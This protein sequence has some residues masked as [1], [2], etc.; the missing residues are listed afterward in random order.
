MSKKKTLLSAILAIAFCMSLIAGSTFALFTSESRVNIAVNSGKVEVVASVSG[1][2]TFSVVNDDEVEETDANYAGEI[3]EDKLGAGKYKYVAQPA[4]QFSEGGTAVYENG[5]L[6]LDKMI[7]GD[8]VT[9]NVDIENNSN[10]KIQ[11][12]TRIDVV[13]DATLFSGLKINIY[14]EDAPDTAV[15]QEK[16]ATISSWK[17]WDPSEDNVKIVKIEIVLPITA[18]NEYQ[19]KGI[20]L[21]FAVEAVQGNAAWA[22]LDRI[23][24]KLA[25][26]MYANANMFDALQD[27]EGIATEDVIKE[28]EFLWNSETDQFT[29]LSAATTDKIKYFKIYDEMPAA[30]SYSIYASSG[31]NTA[32]VN[33]LKVGFDA[34]NASGI[35][36]VTYDRSDAE[37]AQTVIIRTTGG[38]L[39]VNAPLDTVIH[40]GSAA[41]VNIIAAAN[42]SYHEFGAVTFVEIAKGRVALENGSNVSQVHIAKVENTD[43]FDEIILAVASDVK[44]S[45]AG[46]VS[47]AAANETVIT[48]DDVAIAEGGTLVVAL[49]SGTEDITDN[50]ELDYVW[51][52]KQGIYEQIKISDSNESAATSNTVWADDDKVEVKTQSTAMAI[53]NNISRDSETNNIDVKVTISNEA[54]TKT[55]KV[56][57]D[58]NR[59][60][61]VVDKDDEEQTVIAKISDPGSVTVNNTEYTI[62]FASDA[63]NSTE[64][65]ATNSDDETDVVRAPAVENAGLSKDEKTKIRDSAIIKDIEEAD[66]YTVRVGTKGYTD[67]QDALDNLQSNQNIY[68]LADSETAVTIAGV[69][70]V[71]LYLNGY[72]ISVSSG[73][74]LSLYDC[75]DVTI[76]NGALVGQIRVGEHHKS[77]VKWRDQDDCAMY[78]WHPLA[79][80]QNVALN[81]VSVTAIGNKP[82]F[83]F[84]N[85]EDDLTRADAT[86]P[87]DKDL[88]GHYI[89]NE[90]T[91]GYTKATFPSGKNTD[92]VVF[93]FFEGTDTVTVNGGVYT[94]AMVGNIADINGVLYTDVLT[95]E[96][97]TFS[98]DGLGRFIADGKYLV[99]ESSA[100]FVVSDTAPENYTA[101]INNVYYTYE[102]GA[103]D[104]ITF[105][106][107]GETVYIRE[108]AA[109]KKG[110]GHSDVLT[111]VYEADGIEYTGAYADTANYV[112]VT[113]QTDNVVVFSTEFH[114]VAAVYKTANTKSPGALTD[115]IL[116]DKFG[117][118]EEAFVA[119]GD[120][121]TIVLLSDYTS[122]AD[123]V[124]TG[125]VKGCVDI[126]K[127]IRF[128]LNGYTWTYTGTNYVFVDSKTSGSSA[129]AVVILDSSPGKT[130]TVYAPNGY[131][132][133]KY[134][135]KGEE[136]I[137][138]SGNFIAKNL[139]FYLYKLS[140]QGGAATFTIKGGSYQSTNS[141]VIYLNGYKSVANGKL[142]IT[143]GSLVSP[144]GK[145][146]ISIL[147]SNKAQCITGSGASYS[148]DP[149]TETVD[150]PP[151]PP[152]TC[153][154]EGTLVTLAD[155]SKKPIEEITYNDSLLVYNFF[156]G[157]YETQDVAL[158]VNHGEGV[159]DVT[160]LAFDDGSCLRIIGDHGIYD[161]DLNDFVYI[162]AENYADF[163]G[164]KFVKEDRENGGIKAVALL[165][166]TVSQEETCAY[167]LTSAKTS[168]AFAEGLLTVAPPEEFYNW[169]AM[170]GFMKYDVE[171]FEKDVETYGTYDYAVFADYVTYEQFVNFNGAYLKIPVEKGYFTF[172]YIVELIRL[173]I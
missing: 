64:L 69:S 171:Q 153:F 79:P 134:N 84:T 139:V 40:Y 146:N 98:N 106:N 58:E 3:A 82:I 67:L 73:Y 138:E 145:A 86:N 101:K 14:N 92:G 151:V 77:V 55:Y 60:L 17:Q 18:G 112:I 81:D 102:G 167:S 144:S 32:E 91:N 90:S 8:K 2:N 129:R 156:T 37:D 35:T 107:F 54:E 95:I 93:T 161:Y 9:F 7:P 38:S 62:G 143:G 165:S 130:G 114:A 24:T 88:Y 163:I 52:T 108:D 87:V 142:E 75:T 10:V 36:S 111:V 12:R 164:H 173:Y 74:V 16:K 147:S 31:W 28:K 96:N 41:N 140:V 11:Y 122:T 15:A 104:A 152:A 99:G 13:G 83:Y 78:G 33:D 89:Y 51:L 65:I 70:N 125:G 168:N 68:L 63:A 30:Q 141:N 6:T 162:N 71:G 43:I 118:V 150:T 1:L 127:G 155:G 20:S 39:T 94:G 113:E 132:L 44:I 49:Q 117:T 5:T 115:S 76:E 119:A 126:N 19:D 169:I 103:D 4:G 160:A 124:N 23:N 59:D 121:N 116:L 61:I 135:S 25:N 133:Y 123:S 66:Y 149:I 172:D 80:A 21:R 131:I 42:S 72:T 50:T 105:A 136:T 158:I 47:Q 120:Y 170:S 109:V 157:N 166:A 110:F 154:A 53:A 85:I 97:G 27:L 46:A 26:E 137:F 100:S 148:S 48:R 22:L 29:T 34:G 45:T 159:Y 128:D 56:E 57:L